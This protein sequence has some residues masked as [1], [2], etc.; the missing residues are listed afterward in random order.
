MHK[1]KDSIIVGAV[2]SEFNPFHNGHEYCIKKLRE[3]GATHIV[4]IMSGCFVQRGEAACLMPYARAEMAVES[5][6]DLVVE[7]PVC[8]SLSSA[9]NFAMGSVAIAEFSGCVDLLGFGA[10][11]SEE[12]F[13]KAYDIILYATENE[14]EKI[15]EKMEKGMPYPVAL[16]KTTEEISGCNM[17]FLSDG[18]NVLALNYI[19]SLD[20]LNSKIKPYFIK[21]NGSSHD[22]LEADK[23]GRVSASFIRKLIAENKI[24]ELEN[25]MPKA[26]YKIFKRECK[27]G[28]FF[29]NGIEQALLYKLRMSD[30]SD[31]LAIN[32]IGRQGLAERMMKYKDAESLDIYLDSVKTKRYP[33]ARIK[34][35]ILSLALGI[36]SETA[37]ILPQY[38]KILAFNKKGTEILKEIKKNSSIPF[39]TSLAKLEN[40]NEKA[41]S[42]AIADAKA[43]ALYTLGLEKKFK[44]SM[45]YS[46]K[47]SIKENSK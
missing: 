42:L 19:M 36:N 20:K 31:F 26:A 1:E 14:C 2:I 9:E 35:H 10:E 40:V 12:E 47:I 5:G 38:S 17:N 21:R 8:Y 11:C 25:Y 3:A 32:E 15:N 16:Q 22:S 39:S 13:K 41:K 46:Q 7:L 18:N 45:A 34:R 37:H 6:A 28:R 23:S 24:S 4:C 33:M 43:Y 29:S 44:G 30:I 27:E